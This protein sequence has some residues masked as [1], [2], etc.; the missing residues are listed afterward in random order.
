MNSFEKDLAEKNEQGGDLSS[1]LSL[2]KN[3]ISML[4][5]V[6]DV[7][8]LRSNDDN[9][10][11][12]FLKDLSIFK[13]YSISELHKLAN[14]MYL[15][16]F[17][18]DEQI[19]KSGDLGIGFYI[20]VK[21]QVKI[22]VEGAHIDKHSQSELFLDTGDFFGELALLQERSERNAS[23]IATEGTVLLG[24]FRPDLDNLIN[25]D[26]VIAAKFLQTVSSII[27]QRFLNLS[28]E[29]HRMKKS[30]YELREKYDSK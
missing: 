4:R 3:S 12:K 21:G 22:I 5:F 2:N 18:K 20:V 29:Y 10:I 25:T 8:A 24:L 11:A 16:N 27:S 7:S 6:W 30:Y 9:N 15:R 23:A 26:P 1:D 17:E 13:D 28:L 19:F 14:S